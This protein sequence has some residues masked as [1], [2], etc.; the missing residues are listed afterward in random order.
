VLMPSFGEDSYVQPLKD[1]QIAAIA[2]YV[3][4]QYGNAD[5]TVTP[6]DVAVARNGGPVPLLV[7]ARPLMLAAP[8]VLVLLVVFG[9]VVRRRRLRRAAPDKLP[10]GQT[11]A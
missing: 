1:D 2:N 5:V 8:V 9:I 3:L 7:R 6:A 10:P 11:M 4:A